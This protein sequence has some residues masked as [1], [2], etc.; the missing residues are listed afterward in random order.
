[1]VVSQI[2]ENRFIYYSEIF[3]SVLFGI[4]IFVFF[5]FFYSYHLH[6]AEQIQLFLLTPDFF[7]EKISFPGGFN[8]Y[9]GGFLTQ[10]FYL[11]YAGALIISILLIAIQRFTK[12]I[13]REITDSLIIFPLAY[14]PSLY[15]GLLLLNELYPIAAVT[16]ILG[17]LMLGWVYMKIKNPGYRF[18]AGIFLIPSAYYLLGGACLALLLIIL[19]FELILKLKVK[20]DNTI[21]ENNSLKIWHFLSYIILGL[22]I[23]FM[24]MRF[25]IL[26]PLILSF[27]SE[28]YYNI[29]NVL[30]PGI[31][32]LFLIPSILMLIFFIIPVRY[33]TNKYAV[34]LQVIIVLAAGYLGYR[35]LVNFDAEKTMNYDY[36]V[37]IGHWKEV[38]STAAKNP[39]NNNL[40]LAMLNL[41]LAKTDQLGDKMF[42]Y[43][44]HG[45][46]GLFL[47]FT[48]EYITPM[49]G[50]EILY[51][52][53]LI[54]ASQEYIFE[55]MEIMPKMGKTVR[56]IKRLA[57]TNLINGQYR[58]SEKYLKILEK[59]MFYSHWA[60]DTERYLYNEEMINRH[61]DWGEKRKL[62][63]KQDFFFHIDDIESIL[64]HILR[65]NPQN[66]LAFEYLMAYCLLD[67]EL[68]KFIQFFPMI[69]N[70]NYDKIPTS[71][72]EAILLYT[73]LTNN[74]PLVDSRLKISETVKSNMKAYADIYINNPNAKE[75]LKKHYSGTYWY[76]LHYN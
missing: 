57:E 20:N 19:V 24:I 64:H 10:F 36:L 2:K 74:D 58:V 21:S 25:F 28:Y 33:F 13:L 65:D 69:K 9:L 37:R 48:N 17:A 22:G 18:V 12:H 40:S 30:P 49:M 61:P 68:G 54:N 70:F 41:S 46:D 14:F 11:P 72:Q 66:K 67:K 1:M 4:L 56:A 39:P 44:Q 71:Y 35:S 47:R 53:G 23:P 27:L 34:F 45:V 51:Q 76:Y 32:I 26:Q 75:I 42:N 6:F 55:S 38:I 60:K 63:V 15:S 5:A 7:L 52:L 50:N 43:G 59:T 31:I 8:G 62:L 16:G 29:P 3:T 73:T